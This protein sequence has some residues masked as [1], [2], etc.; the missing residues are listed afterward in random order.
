MTK[1]LSK[2]LIFSSEHK[3]RIGQSS[4][5]SSSSRA[6]QSRRA[7]PHSRRDQ[8]GD[9]SFEFEIVHDGG[10]QN[11]AR[12]SKDEEKLTSILTRAV[13][14][15]QNFHLPNSYISI[16]PTDKRW[17]R[18]RKRS[19]NNIHS[20]SLPVGIVKKLASSFEMSSSTIKK[21]VNKD[22]L[23]ALVE[24]G[25]LFLEQIGNDLGTFAEHAGRKRIQDADV[26]I[27]MK[28]FAVN[29]LSISFAY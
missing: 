27:L 11:P 21:K 20:L 25:H 28:R 19:G 17:S 18:Q 1:L 8:I 12:S 26:A 14:N 2:D 23:G 13:S 7:G 3:K 15:T 29:C 22:T 10:L 5:H 6:S 4:C 9:T 24:A 16:A